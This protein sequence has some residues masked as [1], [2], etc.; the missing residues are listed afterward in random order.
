MQD[1]SNT[2]LAVYSDIKREVWLPHKDPGA[3]EWWYFDAMSDDGSEAIVIVFFEDLVFSPR[4]K[5][6]TQIFNE[7]VTSA[8]PDS[9]NRLPAVS[10]LY[11]RDEKPVYRL[12]NEYEGTKFSYDQ[13]ERWYCVGKS[14]FRF[15]SAAYGSGFAISLDLPLGRG[16]RVE[17]HF[18]WL[19]IEADLLA[20]PSNGRYLHEMN[21][22][23]PRADV[24][25]RISVLDRAGNAKDVRHFRGT[26]YHDHELDDR[27]LANMVEFRHRGKAHFADRTV[28]FCVHSEFDSDVTAADLF[29]IEDNKMQRL[30]VLSIDQKFG[31]NKFGV[32]YPQSLKMTAADG[33]RLDVKPR[34]IIDSG[35]YYLRFLSGL[36]LT[37]PDGSVR[38]GNGITEFVAPKALKNRW[39]G[40]IS[41]MRLRKNNRES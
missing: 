31:R 30:R 39:L 10:L 36:T 41:D 29:V 23:V 33:T 11:F 35:F 25:G 16:R 37:A 12:L 18:E 15:D 4:Y 34:R 40:W 38:D 13:A 9:A 20:S 17:A 26:G 8:A 32:K 21:L 24:T 22:A 5:H 27:W 19:S 7:S 1:T 14:R 6:V 3:N 2:S 28:I